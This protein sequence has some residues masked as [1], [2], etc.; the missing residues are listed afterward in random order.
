MIRQVQCVPLDIR[1]CRIDIR[2]VKE[3]YVVHVNINFVI[4]F[5]K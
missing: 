5:H 3:Q 1:A 2:F 4:F